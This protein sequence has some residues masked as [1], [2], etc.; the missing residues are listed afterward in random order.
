MEHNSNLFV[1]AASSPAASPRQREAGKVDCGDSPRGSNRKLHDESFGRHYDVGMTASLAG[2]EPVIVPDRYESLARRAGGSLNSIVVPVQSALAEID[3]IYGRMHRADRG[4]FLVLRGASGAGKSTFLHTLHMYRA[5][6]LTTSVLAD[7]SIREY[8]KKDRPNALLE[9]LVL[10]ERE[11]AISFSNQELEYW[12][13]AINGFIR[14]DRGRNSI[15]VWPCNTDEL[16]DR[17]VSLGKK[18]GGNS[19][20]GNGQGWFD[21]PGP[22][23]DEYRSIAEKTLS[24]LNQGA[25]LS[26]LGL[27]TAIVE[28]VAKSSSTIGDFLSSIHDKI[29]IAENSVAKLLKQENCRLWIIVAAGND[30]ESEVAALTRG[31]YAAVDTEGMM[32]STDANII[33]ELKSFPDKIGILGTV[34][35][36]K[37]FHLPIL[38]AS[39]IARAFSDKKLKDAM[40]LAGLSLKPDRKADAVER[41]SQTELASILKSG[42]QG[43]LTRGKKPGSESVDAFEK[44][45]KIASNDD[46]SLNRALG[47]ALVEAGLIQSFEVEQD[48]GSGLTRRTDILAKTAAGPIRIEV[49]WRSSTSRAA[50]ANYTLTKLSNYGRAIGFLV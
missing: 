17:I 47:A 44:L 9:V 33:K 37:I 49:M 18:I 6:V 12:L 40:Q 34:L 50:I 10:E 46:V 27:T 11:A 42:S 4:A 45:A 16:R 15:V 2:T 31:R 20:V 3:A 38:T 7:Q 13:H 19:L 36:A 48:F 1:A 14:S 41:L 35:D 32:S 30:I 43:L 8:L 29:A 39:A 22:N 21:F 5:G 26:D 25:T 28:E 23:T 24:T